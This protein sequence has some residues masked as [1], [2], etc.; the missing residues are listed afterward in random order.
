MSGFEATHHGV[1]VGGDRRVYVDPTRFV[2]TKRDRS[3]TYAGV[4]VT[5][6]TL[7]A[8]VAAGFTLP[9]SVQSAAKV[10]GCATEYSSSASMHYC[11]T[12]DPSRALVGVE[13]L[14]FG[15]KVS[16]RI[17]GREPNARHYWIFVDNK[18]TT[19]APVSWTAG[20]YWSQ[21][22][23]DIDLPDTDPHLVTIYASNVGGIIGLA[24]GASGALVPSDT[25]RL[26]L[27]ITGDSF[28]A[29]NSMT[30][31][32]AFLSF[33]GIMAVEYGYD[34]LNNGIGGT[35]YVNDGGGSILKTYAHESRIKNVRLF[36]PDVHVIFGSVND[37][38]LSGVTAAVSAT[39]SAYRAVA[40]CKTV[41]VGVEPT[42][43]DKTLVDSVVT[44]KAI[45]A[46]V[47]GNSM[48]DTYLDPIGCADLSVVPSAFAAGTYEV[49]A[50]VAA[51][52]AIFELEADA[53]TSFTATQGPLGTDASTKSHRWKMLTRW[54]HGTGNV[55]SG[56]GTR[57]LFL[58]S[59]NTH[60]TEA[61]NRAIA[62]TMDQLI[63]Q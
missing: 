46:A 20:G 13:S 26:K 48:V 7:A 45:H 49:G 52:N 14:V 55:S 54:L 18:P 19:S 35:G 6:R 61:G 63:K 39:I 41:V 16:L 24:T 9:H 27:A 34:V 51:S 22:C 25:Q 4:T 17:Y 21:Q 59:D 58:G 50:K 38:G 40:P 3:V 29:G 56:T 10:L 42:G 12:A 8:S 57:A 47:S 11:L 33:A 44:A 1:P 2:S 30:S 53:A 36:D 28:V 15:G 43:T 32:N 23:I 62:V 37:N 31:N 5:L 60:Y